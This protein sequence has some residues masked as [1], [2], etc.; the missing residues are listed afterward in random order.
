MSRTSPGGQAVVR[1][2]QRR[3]PAEQ[4]AYDPYGAQQA[5][6]QHGYP[7]QPAQQGGYWG[8][9]QDYAE[10][11]PH[12]SPYGQQPSPYGQQPAP[13]GQP[14]QHAPFGQ[15]TS[16][17]GQQQPDPYAEQQPYGSYGAAPGY[18]Q[19]HQPMIPAP[20]P[21]GQP[22]GY[23]A[24]EQEPHRQFTPQAPSQPMPFD[25][26]PS[27]APH[28][29][30][31]QQPAPGQGWPQQAQ[32]AHDPRGF[33]LGH[34][35][36]AGNPQQHAEPQFHAGAPDQF[37][38]GPA[39][40]FNQPQQDYADP[41]AGY[42]DGE[43]EEEE[44]PRSGRR[45]LMIAAALVGAIGIGGAMAY[46][47]KSVF[48]S[49]KPGSVKTADL[50]AKPTK[51]ASV[52]EKKLGSRLDDAQPAA[53]EPDGQDTGSDDPSAPKKVRIIQIP[54]TGQTADATAPPPPA[55]PLPGI[56]LDMGP[57]PGAQPP[58]AMPM[59]G[60]RP[61]AQPMPSAPPTANAGPKPA[62]APP[63]R[64]VAVAPPAPPEAPAAPPAKKAKAEKVEKTAVPKAKDNQTASIPSSGGA[65]FVAVLSSQKTRMDALK[66][67]ADLQQKYNDVLGTKTPDVQEFNAGDKGRWYR[68]VVGPPG[69]RE[70]AATLCTQLKASGHNGCWVTAY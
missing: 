58:A 13:Y 6:Q 66:A 27:P 36:P 54:P 59:P 29:Y 49:P 30:A 46:T 67:F 26:F 39:D 47:Y 35:M 12:P 41:E 18:A 70:A 38:V 68:A 7:Q 33:D 61:G 69:S 43:Q 51:E 4:E 63:V 2:P 15:Q 9:Q 25:R 45:M 52:S 24:P 53:Q 21:F 57:R 14:L 31:G 11:H 23:G 48:P 16:A 42:D 60:A 65:G 28:G 1:M 37:N 64:T 5:P 50:K 22:Q 8:Q 19:Q 40:H 32:P 44:A 17:Y 34:Y 56:M 10:Q 55:T 20:H 62:A 3:Q